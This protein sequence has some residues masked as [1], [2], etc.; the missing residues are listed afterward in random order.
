MRLVEEVHEGVGK[1]VEAGDLAID[2]TIGNGYDTEFL[3][4]LGA[5]VI[6]FD[7]QREAILNTEKRLKEGGNLEKVRLY[8][9]GHER[10]V[11][12][13]PKDWVENVQVVMFNLGYLPGG[14]KGCITR[15]ETT[16][17]GLESAYY[18]LKEG[19]YLSVM[20]YPDH[21]GGADE[22]R[23]VKAWILGIEGE[24]RHVRPGTRGPEWYWVRKSC[25][26]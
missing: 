14:D 7:I 8:Q 23:A 24:V 16:L 26:G 15:A 3:V 12:F 1:V 11:E 25:K 10:M 4:K 5:Q 2:A 18:L 19:G 6:G 9:E 13:V 20:L 17:K 22:A 21:E